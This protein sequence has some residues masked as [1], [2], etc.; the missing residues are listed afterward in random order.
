[1]ARDVDVSVSTAGPFFDYRVYRAMSE[2][3]D[4]AEQ[5]VADNGAELVRAGTTVFRDPTGYYRSRVH[6]ETRG[7]DQVVTDGDVVYGAWLEGDGSRNRTSSFKGYKFWR[8]AA[9]QLQARAVPI[10]ED[11]LRR[12]IGGMS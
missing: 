5:A 9:Q 11:E 3:C 10:A 8:L 7:G 1:M 12:H 6:T 2:Y 4:A